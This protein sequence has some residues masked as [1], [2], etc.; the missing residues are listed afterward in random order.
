[1]CL[2]WL[3]LRKE[4]RQELIIPSSGHGTGTAYVPAVCHCVKQSRQT[5]NRTVHHHIRSYPSRNLIMTKAL[6]TITFFTLSINA[7]RFRLAF[8]QIYANWRWAAGTWSSMKITGTKLKGCFSPWV[9]MW[10][11]GTSLHQPSVFTFRCWMQTHEEISEHCE[12][13]LKTAA[14]TPYGVKAIY[15]P[16]EGNRRSSAGS[17]VL[18]CLALFWEPCKP[19]S[20]LTSC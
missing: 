20:D 3:W 19:F 6:C 7:T 10:M 14:K 16:S 5:D 2:P 18:P 1:M 13:E 11:I 15:K 8:M 4:Q 9:N 12:S 17:C